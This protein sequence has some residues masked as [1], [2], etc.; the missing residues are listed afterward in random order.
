M[1]A[2]CLT[3]VESTLMAVTVASAASAP[4]T[5][6][7]GRRPCRY[8]KDRPRYPVTNGSRRSKWRRAGRRKVRAP[9]RYG[10]PR[11]QRQPNRGKPSTRTRTSAVSRQ[12]TMLR[13]CGCRSSSSNSRAPRSRRGL[14]IAAWLDV[15]GS[16][17]TVP[18]LPSFASKQEEL[19]DPWSPVPMK[20]NNHRQLTSF[21]TA[22]P[23]PVSSWPCYSCTQPLSCFRSWWNRVPFS[24]GGS[25]FFCIVFVSGQ[26]LS[27]FLQ[28]MVSSLVL[29]AIGQYRV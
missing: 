21:T 14:C 29:Q 28:S 19:V 23:F 7:S 1:L 15:I 24:R 17:P 2:Q 11:N 27:I 20:Q 16:R 12:N 13:R 18:H 3:T 22:R 10:R 5:R 6:D 8:C 4:P 26:V 9:V 25:H